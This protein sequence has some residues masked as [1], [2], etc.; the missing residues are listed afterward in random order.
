[1]VNDNN[2]FFIRDINFSFLL[3]RIGYRKYSYLEREYDL[4]S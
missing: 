1:M 4:I 3:Y 2:F